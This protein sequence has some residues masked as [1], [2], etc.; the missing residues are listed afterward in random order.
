M[1]KDLPYF[2][3]YC[4]EWSDGD[5][6]LEDMSIQGLFVNVCA[7][8][9]SNEC[10]LTLAK[11]KKKFRQVSEKD[12]DTLIESGILKIDSED[13]LIINF[14]NEQM[15]EREEKSKKNSMNGS[16]GGRPKKANEKPNESEKKAN[17]LFLESE[18]KP[19]QKPLREEERREEEIRKEKIIEDIK[20]RKQ[21]FKQT[22]VP[23]LDKYGKDMINDF[24]LYW[25]QESKDGKL[26]FELEKTWSVE[27]RLNTWHKRSFNNQPQQ[28][29]L[30]LNVLPPSQYKKHE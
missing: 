5:I 18:T 14:L 7:Y 25:T 12:F 28:T 15:N 13:N 19:K 27:A 23:F 16:L 8:Y 4:S 6:S 9:W 26:G 1:A 24:L 3:F 11:C 10:K 20:F 21:N 17:G 30:K 22:L 29:Q 2:K